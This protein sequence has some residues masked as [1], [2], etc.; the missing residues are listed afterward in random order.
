MTRRFDLLTEVLGVDCQRA[1]AWTLGRVL[2]G[3][4][5]RVEAGQVLNGEQVAI[6]ELLLGRRAPAG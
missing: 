4:L 3:A 6:A 5:W 1:R 2:E